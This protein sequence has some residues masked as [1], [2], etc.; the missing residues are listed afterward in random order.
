MV[1]DFEKA[2][3]LARDGRDAVAYNKS[4]L[5][6]FLSVIALRVQ[7]ECFSAV[8]VSMSTTIIGKK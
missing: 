4:C 2:H 5:Y 7:K 1:F 6:L 3:T 8:G